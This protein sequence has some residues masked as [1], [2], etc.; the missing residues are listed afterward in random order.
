[1]KPEMDNELSPFLDLAARFA[2]NELLPGLLER[3][4]YPVAPFSEKVVNQAGEAGLLSVI[5][6][7]SRGG[8]GQGMRAL[9]AILQTLAE[10]DA[11]FAAVLLV[12]AMAQFAM[13]RWG[14]EAHLEPAGNGPLTAFPAYSLPSDSGD[15]LEATEEEQGFRLQGTAEYLPLAPVAG[16]FVL[17]ARIG[18]DG[19]TPFFRVSAGAQ[20]VEVGEPVLSLGLRSCPAADV[21]LDRVLV[22]RADRLRGDAR[23]GFPVLASFFRPAVAALSLGVLAG[24]LRTARRYAEERYQ[25]GGTIAGHDMVRLM[26]A[27]MAVTVETGRVLV[28]EMAEAAD[29]GDPGL[30]LHAG[31][32][33]LGEQAALAAGDGVQVLGGYGYM[34]DYGQE[35][36]MRD[37]K[38]I[39]SFFGGSAAGRLDLAA[40]FLRQ[41]P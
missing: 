13:L 38:Q 27:G 4:D 23:D 16:F 19:A 22:P 28:R 9:A 29:R 2:G 10:T 36:R 37:A 21:R 40:A 8:A 17:P 30:L 25:G 24:S 5:L 35:K 31:Q 3:D 20:G 41:D 7:E 26:L 6:P 18:A 33:F 15:R 32:I 14:N 34:Q 11:G 39:E 1:M 12:N